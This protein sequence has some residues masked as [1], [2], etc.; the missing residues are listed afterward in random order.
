MDI[1]QLEVFVAVAKHKSFSKAARELFLTQPTVSSH[2]QNLEN[3]MQTVLLN[4]NNKTITLTDSGHILYNHAIVILNDCKKA[5]YDIKE[6]SGKIEGSI[7]IVCSSVPEAHLFPSFL[8]KFCEKYPNITF[9][10]NHCNSNLVIPEILSERATFGIVGSKQKHP[11]ID[12]YDLINDELVLICPPDCEIENDNGYIDIEK[13]RDL[14]FIMR[15]EGSGTRNVIIKKLN[16]SPVPP[17]ALKIRA[18]VE[19]NNAI[20][21][22]V[23]NGLGCSFV[24]EISA[25]YL[26]DKGELKEYRIKNHPFDRNFYFIFSKK[27][28]FTPTEKKFIEYLKDFYDLDIDLQIFSS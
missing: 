9:T 18:Y 16:A 8:N 12:Y 26:I 3:E 5:V 27:K 15:K 2:I 11:H 4:R 23:R 17:S 10:I 24:S 21:E 25:R 7:S 19:S 13:L 20:I 28:V 14:T 1:K 22:M 6:Y